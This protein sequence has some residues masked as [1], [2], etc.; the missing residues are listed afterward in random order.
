MIV[1]GI[2][3]NVATAILGIVGEFKQ[4]SFAKKLVAFARLDPRV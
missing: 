1:P 3:S 4:F 2:S